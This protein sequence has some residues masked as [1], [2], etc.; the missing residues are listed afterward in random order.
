MV[1]E[2]G[3]GNNTRPA[4]LFPASNDLVTTC[5]VSRPV[6]SSACRI[7]IRKYW[8]HGPTIL[9]LLFP[10]FPSMKGWQEECMGRVQIAGS[11]QVY[12]DAYSL[13]WGVHG[14][15]QR[16]PCRF[17]TSQSDACPPG[18]HCLVMGRISL[19][20]IVGVSRRCHHV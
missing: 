13:P 11:V 9:N 4:A 19:D 20:I 10:S 8:V 3:N 1:L 6:V 17:V 18:Q 7:P 2:T 12:L 16:N 15:D 5:S 14:I